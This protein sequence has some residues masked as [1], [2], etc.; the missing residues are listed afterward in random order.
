MEY[1]VEIY[2]RDA[3]TLAGERL[4]K[5]IDLG[6]ITRSEA[7]NIAMIY[8]REGLRTELHETYVE[9]VNLM[10]GARYKERYD[11]PL[12]CSPSSE[13]FWSM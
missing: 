9:M 4:V 6:D 12:S 3:R 10:T 8:E 7:D 2:K 11:T 1:T 13:T 5:K